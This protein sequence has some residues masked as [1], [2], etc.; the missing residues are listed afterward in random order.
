VALNEVGGEPDVFGETVE[1]FHHHNAERFASFPDCLVAT[2][3]HDTKRSEDVRARMLVLTESPITWSR[4]VERWLDTFDAPDRNDGWMVA[5]TVVG[6]WPID[7]DRLAQYVTKAVREEKL[8]TSWT[9]PDEAY[10]ARILAFAERL[11]ASGEVEA[12]VERIAERGHRNSLAATA[13]RLFAPGVPDVYQGSEVEFLALVDPDNRRP[14]D[15]ARLGSLLDDALEYGAAPDKLRLVAA[16]LRARREHP[17]LFARGEYVPV[18]IEAPGVLAFARRAGDHWALVAVPLPGF[19]TE[20]TA[21]IELPEGAPTRWRH[22]VIGTEHEPAATPVA[23]LF[24]GFP[25]LV[26]LAD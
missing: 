3:T 11:R 24:E 7:A 2:S 13:L 18:R 20:S 23:R 10:E 5:S 15:Y 25:V 4:I 1:S 21:A 22:V 17:E 8:R 19:Q 26:A 12:I 9:D 14:V 16:C 6:A